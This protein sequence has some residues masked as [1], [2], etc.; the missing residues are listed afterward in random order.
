MSEDEGNFSEI[1]KFLSSLHEPPEFIEFDFERGRSLAEKQ[2]AAMIAEYRDQGLFVSNGF[3]VEVHWGTK[4]KGSSKLIPTD[5]SGRLPADVMADLG[6]NV[7]S[8]KYEVHNNTLLEHFLSAKVQFQ[9]LARDVELKLLST[10]DD[11]ITS[12][13]S[14]SVFEL[15]AS[16]FWKQSETET[17]TTLATEL[18]LVLP[19]EMLAPHND[20]ER[21]PRLLLGVEE[22]E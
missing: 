6:P 14:D 11:V 22:E 15:D 19:M 4:F 9:V 18:R 13:P 5:G 8:G 2:D 7:I 21:A 10:L 20:P 1:E 12:G 3:I 17:G 16:L